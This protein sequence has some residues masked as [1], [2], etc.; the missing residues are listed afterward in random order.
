[1]LTAL[2]KLILAGLVI[3]LAG[4]QLVMYYNIVVMGTYMST[5]P[6]HLMVI[7]GVMWPVIVVAVAFVALRA[8][9]RFKPNQL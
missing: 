6:F 2:V 1:M 8:I 3:A 9:I 5:A 7:T 4:Q